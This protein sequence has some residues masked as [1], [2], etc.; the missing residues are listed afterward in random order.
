MDQ[1]P[2]LAAVAVL[3]V[4]FLAAGFAAGF[5]AAGFATGFFAAG[6]AA[7]FFAAGFFAALTL[8]V[9]FFAVDFVATGRRRTGDRQRTVRFQPTA[10]SDR[11]EAGMRR[12]LSLSSTTDKT[13]A[14]ARSARTSAITFAGRRAR[15]A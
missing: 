7:G 6:F 4:Y 12:M 13:A 8:E 5:F 1:F 15:A 2:D 11:N 9:V 3:V 14:S 10:L